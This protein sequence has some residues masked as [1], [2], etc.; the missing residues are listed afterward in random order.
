MLT[1]DEKKILR[2]VKAKVKKTHWLKGAYRTFRGRERKT[3]GCLA[4]LVNIETKCQYDRSSL[5]PH[6]APKPNQKQRD[7]IFEALR[8]A[9]GYRYI[10]TWNDSSKTTRE[11][12]VSLIDKTIESN[13][14]KRSR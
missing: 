3:C 14:K 2:R 8:V 5:R 7:N 4:G 6:I 9:L 13:T 11:D 12:V 1:V 10:E